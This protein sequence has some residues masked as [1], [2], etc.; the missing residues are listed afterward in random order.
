MKARSAVLGARIENTS[1]ATM[2][3][4]LVLWKRGRKVSLTQKNTSIL[5]DRYLGSLNVS[6][7]FLDKKAMV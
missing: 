1:I 2:I 7:K 4:P 5:N 6:G 3:F